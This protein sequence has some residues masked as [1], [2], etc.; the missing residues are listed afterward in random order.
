MF[1]IPVGSGAVYVLLDEFAWTNTGLDQGDNARVLAEILGR[2]I[3]GGAL[4]FDE[5]RHGHG[6]AESFLAY[7]LNLPGSSAIMWLGVDLG[8]SLLLWPERPAQAGRSV[9]GAGTA[10]RS[11]VY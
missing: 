5:Y 7:L 9:C 8:A 3:R 4:A 6:R 1:R 11:R 10:D 2:E